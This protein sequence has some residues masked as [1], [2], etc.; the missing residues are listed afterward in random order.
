M[1]ASLS[2]SARITLLVS[3]VLNV[4]LLALLLGSHLG[5]R[6]HGEHGH[7]RGGSRLLP[8]FSELRAFTRELPEPRAQ[9]VDEVIQARRESLRARI[10][11]LVR[12]RRAVHAVIAQEPFE[13]QQLDAAF[14]QLRT[15]EVEAALQAQALLGDVLEHSSVEERARLLQLMQ[16]RSSRRGRRAPMQPGGSEAERVPAPST[17]PLHEP[18]PD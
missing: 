5:Q 3:L 7:G 15:A 8:Y 6:M 4:L 12:A 16:S 9:Q 18:G 1:S 17:T 13:R 11:E 2:R 10:I 14:A